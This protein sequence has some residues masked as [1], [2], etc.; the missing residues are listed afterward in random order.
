MTIR[1]ALQP[2]DLVARIGGDEFAILLPETTRPAAERSL[3]ESERHWR[4]PCRKDRRLSPS[5]SAS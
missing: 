2:M 1:D 3:R 5:A 4:R